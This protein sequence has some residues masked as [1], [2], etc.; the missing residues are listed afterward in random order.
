MKYY[1]IT[2]ADRY[3]PGYH[4]VLNGFYTSKEEAEKAAE[5]ERKHPDPF[6]NFEVAV[7]ELDLSDIRDKFV[8]P[9]T[10]EKYDAMMREA[11]EP[12][13]QSMGSD[14]NIDEY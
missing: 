9:M 12:M 3:D 13:L 14:Y 7:H 2:F 8:P 11:Y 10:E 5:W 1:Q 4:G 6:T